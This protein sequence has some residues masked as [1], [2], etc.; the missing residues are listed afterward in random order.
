[1]QHGW[2][3]A[4]EPRRREQCRKRD[5]ATYLR[6]I[7]CCQAVRRE[8]AVQIARSNSSARRCANPSKM[9]TAVPR[10]SHL[11]GISRI[12]DHHP[13]MRALRLG[14]AHLGS[15]DSGTW[16]RFTPNVFPQGV[17]SVGELGG[18]SV[19]TSS[20]LQQSTLMSTAELFNRYFVRRN[21]TTLKEFHSCAVAPLSVQ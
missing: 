15:G 7:V 10:K 8:T 5:S 9:M 17:L 21:L 2:C 4:A 1:M 3:S 11:G 19:Q 20:R 14:A 18:S 12:R 16:R 6:S 13:T